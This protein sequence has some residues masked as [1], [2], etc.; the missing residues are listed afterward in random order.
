MIF[1]RSIA[2][3]L[4]SCIV[5][6]TAPLSQAFATN[7]VA[8]ISCHQSYRMEAINPRIAWVRLQSTPHPSVS[9]QVRREATEELRDEVA[10]TKADIKHENRIA[11]VLDGGVSLCMY[12]YG[13]VMELYALVRATATDPNDESKLYIQNPKSTERVYRKLAHVLSKPGI[14]QDQDTLTIRFIIDTI[15]GTSAGGVNGVILAKALALDQPLAGLGQLWVNEGDISSLLNDAASMKGTLP[16]GS[17]FAL[18]SEAPP[19]ALLNGDRMYALLIGA[20]EQ[21]DKARPRPVDYV[22]PYVSRLD[23]SFTSTDTRGIL[24]EIFIR[25]AKIYDKLHRNVFRLLYRKDLGDAGPW[26]A[27]ENFAHVNDFVRS[28]NAFLAYVARCTSSF[29]GAF[30]PSRAIDILK[31][32]ARMTGYQ[33]AEQRRE[34]GADPTQWERF[35]PEYHRV[36]NQQ[37]AQGQSRP[38]DSADFLTAS[39]SDGGTLNNEPIDNARKSLFDHWS[40]VPMRRILM[41]VQPVP[42]MLQRIVKKMPNFIQN[43]VAALITIPGHQSNL[44]NLQEIEERN[45]LIRDINRQIRRVEENLHLASDGGFP[46]R[47]DPIQW[48][49]ATLATLQ[50]QRGMGYAIYHQERMT[51]VTKEFALLL[52]RAAGFDTRSQEAQAINTIVETWVEDKYSPNGPPGSNDNS[53]L[54]DF[55]LGYFFRKLL[56]VRGKITDLSCLDEN[57]KKLVAY[58]NEQWP[59]ESE[60]NDFEKETIG[61]KRSFGNIFRRMN[62][63]RGALSAP[64]GILHERVADANAPVMTLEDLRRVMSAPT[65][66]EK[67]K[68]AH[69]IVGSKKSRMDRFASALAARFRVID[70][71]AHKEASEAL[72][73]T[74]P[75]GRA[76]AR[77]VLRHYYD[78]FEIFDQVTLPLLYGTEVGELSTVDI[79][80]VSPVDATALFDPNKG[81]KLNGD[82]LFHFGAFLNEKWRKNDIRWGRFD[83]AERL[84][85]AMLPEE[86]QAAVRDQLIREAHLAICEDIIRE[87]PNAPF[88][89]DI[90]KSIALKKGEPLDPKAATI[91]LTPEDLL[92]YYK[93]SY[94]LDSSL[95]WAELAKTIA[96]AVTVLGDVF[97]GI[98][99]MAVRLLGRL[100]W[101]VIA[102]GVPWTKAN[103][104]FLGVS[105]VV[106]GSA[107]FSIWMGHFVPVSYG[108]LIAIATAHAV[109]FTIHRF[110]IEDEMSATSRRRVVIALIALVGVFT[111]LFAF[112]DSAFLHMLWTKLLLPAWHSVGHRLMPWKIGATFTLPALF[113]AA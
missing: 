109:L 70:E 12:I 71:Q 103:S 94:K 72:Q 65:E 59:S 50:K 77:R 9:L 60:L 51:Q 87:N 40:P 76:M 108:A 30:V 47:M 66:S 46:S 97:A 99:A 52:T 53:F 39:M 106:A 11:L 18:D 13:I 78:V 20:L 98:G 57:A 42:E 35:F 102:I 7:S 104:I 49:D 75:S 32:I 67:K 21:M 24:E 2:V 36:A 31:V 79:E 62:A 19:Q 26:G 90:A 33:T 93:T 100:V 38:T 1:P 112:A 113:F 101:T 91:P 29:P 54:F 14:G 48:R 83:G 16:D 58:S 45:E 89:R 80:R 41:I 105:A 8:A 81:P 82:A 4:I 17:T 69:A 34:I 25:G 110:I 56:Y 3:S 27:G 10:I 23:A 107:F 5:L 92:D 55:D 64:D 68:V 63:A 43:I 95:D 85:A 37:V 74:A 86:A 15:A 73:E 6:Q 111:T 88:L 84:I 61:A 44:R 22:S 96:R 28:N